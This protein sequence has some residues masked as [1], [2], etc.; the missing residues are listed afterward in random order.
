MTSPRPVARG[1]PALSPRDGKLKLFEKDPDVDG[2]VFE[3]TKNLERDVENFG[4]N[5]NRD[6]ERKPMVPTRRKTIEDTHDDENTE[7][8][9]RIYES[10][11]TTS[12]SVEK[13][14][15]PSRRK[16]A[17]EET[18]ERRKDDELYENER[19]KSLSGKPMAPSRS[20]KTV[21]REETRDKLREKDDGV[22]DYKRTKSPSEKPMAPP[23]S[24]RTVK[25]MHE[26]RR[27]KGH[28][29]DDYERTKSL[30]GKPMAPSRRKKT[31][32][33]THEE[34]REEVDAGYE[35]EKTAFRR[36]KSIEET[37]EVHS[38]PQ[39]PIIRTSA[40]ED[41][42]P[43]VD[44]GRAE[45]EQFGNLRRGQRPVSSMTRSDSTEESEDE[46]DSGRVLYRKGSFGSKKYDQEEVDYD[47]RATDDREKFVTT[48]PRPSPRGRSMVDDILKAHSKVTQPEEDV[49]PAK[50]PGS[51]PSMKKA[52][53]LETLSSKQ[54]ALAKKVPSGPSEH[55]TQRVQ[56]K[57]SLTPQRPMSAKKGSLLTQ[58][59]QKAQAGVTDTFEEHVPAVENVVGAA[60]DDRGFRKKGAWDTGAL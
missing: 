48:P 19:G 56:L 1:R 25:E 33:E 39:I 38:R 26:T 3:Q 60:S 9:V 42:S 15:A 28:G 41:D 12:A 45:M 24:E 36:K 52:P 18:H 43:F 31:F 32:E 11:R 8:D 6:M 59:R 5:R 47:R 4:Y 30:S 23:R 27:G 17:I 51:A 44:R 35:H 16:K 29:V 53:S 37:R 46:D 20:K 49:K 22:Y 10:E 57:K 54:G 34:S 40:F 58:L 55:G 14:M 50:R 2:Y 13:P 21:D 7:R